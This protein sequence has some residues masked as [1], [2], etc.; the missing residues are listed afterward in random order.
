M[1]SLTTATT[2]ATLVGLV[3]HFRQEK[4]EREKL[5]HQKFIE[6]LE[7]HRHEE[8]KN[9]IINTAALRTEVDNL[10]HSDHAIMLQ[11]LDRIGEILASLLSQMSEFR[12]LALA[13]APNAEL[14]EQAISVLRQFVESGAQSFFYNNW[15][16]GN[17]SLGWE[18]GNEIT[19]T[20]LRFLEDDLNKLVELGLLAVR[21]SSSGDPIFGITRNATRFIETIGKNS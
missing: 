13:V 9:L 7:Y 19:I 16:N 3:C 14:S 15:G 20:E 18:A 5:D 17:F 1:D 11:K 6:W 10:L 21:H 8:L 4:G 2:F 12:G